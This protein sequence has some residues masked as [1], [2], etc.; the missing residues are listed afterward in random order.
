MGVIV[1]AGAAARSVRRRYDAKK[2]DPF[3]DGV[4]NQLAE[5]A[6]SPPRPTT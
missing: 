5:R 4:S 3:F 1:P 6:S 2:H